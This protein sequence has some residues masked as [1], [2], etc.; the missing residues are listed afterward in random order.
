M[1]KKIK[2][3]TVV[4]ARPQFIKLS[5]LSKQLRK[6]FKEVVIHTGQHYDKNL[7]DVF[8]KELKLPI[9]DYN[10]NVACARQGEQTARM[11]C[12]IERV[13]QKERPQI[14]MVYGDTNSTLAG[15][16]AAAK[17]NIPIAHVEAGLRSYNRKMPEEIN[18]VLTDHLSAFLFCPTDTAV[19]NLKKEGIVKNVYNVGDVMYDAVMYYLKEAEKCSGILDK[20]GIRN[21]PYYLITVHRAENTDSK[22]KLKKIMDIVSGLDKKVVFPVH[23]RTKKALEVFGI[24]SK[25]PNLLLITPVSYFNMLV[26][27]KNAKVILTD[28]GGVQKEAYMLRVPCITLREETEWVETVNAGWNYL[29][30]VDKNRILGLAAK[31]KNKN[32]DNRGLFGNGAASLSI[33]NIL[34]SVFS[35]NSVSKRER[36]YESYLL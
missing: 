27:E 25:V 30:G 28:S 21:I 33:L 29:G 15:A 13:L 2:I 32:F 4:G 9:P 24:R 20:L 22:D 14:V 34:T 12:G 36:G 18:R 5:P 6:R 8:F 17:L 19:L 10:L 11:I 35:N 23:P 26:L 3:A 31:L 1:D 16:L 7:S